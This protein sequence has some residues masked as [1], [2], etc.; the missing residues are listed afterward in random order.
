MASMDRT[1]EVGDFS[2]TDIIRLCRAVL[3]AAA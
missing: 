1:I 3:D 2:Q